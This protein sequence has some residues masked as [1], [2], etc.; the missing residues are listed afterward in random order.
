MRQTH[1]LCQHDELHI[2]SRSLV[3]L[4]LDSYMQY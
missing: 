2:T 3:R 1:G 4:E